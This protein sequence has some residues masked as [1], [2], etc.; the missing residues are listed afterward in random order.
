MM[1]SNRIAWETGLGPWGQRLGNGQNSHG[2]TKCMA[3]RRQEARSHRLD[4]HHLF[5]EEIIRWR[6]IDVDFLPHVLSPASRRRIQSQL[7]TISYAWP[8]REESGRWQ[9]PSRQLVLS[10]INWQCI[11]FYRQ[12]LAGSCP[13]PAPPMRLPRPGQNPRKQIGQQVRSRNKS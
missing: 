6:G 8:S 4:R 5:Q 13:S 10:N 12:V 7:F 9:F 2:K 3:G 1:A 11:L